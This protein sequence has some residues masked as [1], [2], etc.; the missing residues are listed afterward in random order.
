MGGAQRREEIRSD[1][2]DAAGEV[3]HSQDRPRLQYRVQ[4]IIVPC[5]RKNGDNSTIR[6]KPQRFSGSN[7]FTAPGAAP[8]HEDR[9]QKSGHPHSDPRHSAAGSNSIDNLLTKKAAPPEAPFIASP[10][11]D[12]TCDVFNKRPGRRTPVGMPSRYRRPESLRKALPNHD[13]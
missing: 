11:S 10:C 2:R 3:N 5:L 6:F 8:T 4:Q 12:A 13:G 7:H 9:S 1:E